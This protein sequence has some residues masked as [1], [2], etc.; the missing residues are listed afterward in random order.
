M[1]GG[2]HR[3]QPWLAAA[4]AVRPPGPARAVRRASCPPQ[5]LAGFPARGVVP[6][7][8]AVVAFERGRGDEP[9]VVLARGQQVAD[10]HVARPDPVLQGTQSGASS[11][12]GPGSSTLSLTV[13]DLARD[14]RATVT[15]QCQPA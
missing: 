4:A 5:V 15:A 7:Q 11:E 2:G 12:S 8:E 3:A 9:L 10:A 1:P 6:V 14:A 13:T